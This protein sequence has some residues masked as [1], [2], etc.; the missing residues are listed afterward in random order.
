MT[1]VEWCVQP[2]SVPALSLAFPERIPGHQLLT[3]VVARSLAAPQER[4][5]GS[6]S[7]SPTHW[8]QGGLSLGV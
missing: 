3:L 4:P 7:L 1:S 8:G 5:E 2:E 6:V